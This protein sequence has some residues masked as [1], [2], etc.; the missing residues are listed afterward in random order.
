MTKEHSPAWLW[1]Q[2][3]VAGIG[4]ADAQAQRSTVV[5]RW[6]GTLDCLLLGTGDPG[7]TGS[8]GQ[9]QRLLTATV[10]RRPLDV[11]CVPPCRSRS[12]NLG[13]RRTF[14]TGRLH[15]IGSFVIII[16]HFIPSYYETVL[17]TRGS[18]NDPL[19]SFSFPLVRFSLC[20]SSLSVS[21]YLSGPDSSMAIKRRLRRGELIV[22]AGE[23][24]HTDISDQ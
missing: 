17:E 11:H 5:F 23:R 20:F 8:P 2:Y 21:S 10:H 6:R 3:L 1:S 12:K 19:C 24:C 13:I 7:G 18:V 15:L 14:Q 4:Y 22:L 9:E 16:E